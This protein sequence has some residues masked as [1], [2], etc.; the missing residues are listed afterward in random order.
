MRGVDI[1]IESRS[2]LSESEAAHVR[3]LIAVCNDAERLD[4]KVEIGALRAASPDM[5][6][7]F[8]AYAGQALIGFCTLDGGREIELC[9]AVHP[10]YRRRGIGRALLDA[11]RE[12]CRRRAA[13]KLLLICEDGSRSGQGFLATLAAHRAFAEH[14]MLRDMTIAGAPP[15][16][17]TLT[18][19][20]A[21]SGDQSAIA[22]ITALAFARDELD[23][24]Q[25]LSLDMG[26]AAEWFFIALQGDSPV[27]TLKIFTDPPRAMIYGF[28][29]APAYQGRGYGREILNHTLRL[30]AAE[31][32]M[33]VGLEVDT[34]NQRA[35]NLYTSAGFQ[36]ITTYGYYTLPV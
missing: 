18:V 17:G 10:D 24:L 34:E 12:E 28:A 6:S 35:Y 23:E 9:G 1:Q 26:S 11:A 30:L 4:L 16:S 36:Q 20:P 29:V 14:R 21:T 32:W 13:V 27:G 33:Q 31:G 15:G 2:M 5:S 7:A 19:R 25:R 22:H 3:E 8:L